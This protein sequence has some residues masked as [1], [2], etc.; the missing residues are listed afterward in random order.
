MGRE[1]HGG[2]DSKLKPT[3]RVLLLGIGDPKKFKKGK[4]TTKEKWEMSAGFGGCRV[5]L[6]K[7]LGGNLVEE[8]KKG[9]LGRAGWGR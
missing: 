3:H 8:K 7:H 6:K 4:N 2:N 5:D 1:D 9:K